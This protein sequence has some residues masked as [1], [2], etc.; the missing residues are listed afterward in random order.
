MWFS[1]I[2]DLLIELDLMPLSAHCVG[3]VT[4]V[5]WVD[6]GNLLYLVTALN[7]E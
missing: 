4:M 1:E 2:R 6:G 5:S 7:N 3:H